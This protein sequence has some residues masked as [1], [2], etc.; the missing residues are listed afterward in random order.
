MFR[1]IGSGNAYLVSDQGWERKNVRDLGTLHW[2]FS[3]ITQGQSWKEETKR[4]PLTMQW[5]NFWDPKKRG[6]AT[7]WKSDVQTR[8]KS[9][10][11][12]SLPLL[13]DLLGE[14]VCVCVRMAINWKKSVK[15]NDKIGKLWSILGLRTDADTGD[16]K[17]SQKRVMQ[18]KVQTRENR[19][20]IKTNLGI[21]NENLIWFKKSI[22]FRRFDQK[23]IKT[24][25]KTIHVRPSKPRKKLFDNLA[26][27]NLDR[28]WLTD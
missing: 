24:L 20:K 21:R 12:A 13:K 25:R 6:G 22:Q 10:L 17:W 28:N 18:L 27:E 19:K 14:W 16:W 4:K 3:P 8:Q 5:H 1:L 7:S 15:I 11:I 9:K 23:A 2:H 26:S